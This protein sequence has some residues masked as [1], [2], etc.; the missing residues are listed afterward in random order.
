[1]AELVD[2]ENKLKAKDGRKFLAQRRTRLI[3][4]VRQLDIPDPKTILVA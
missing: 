3:L 1:M 4:G 2:W